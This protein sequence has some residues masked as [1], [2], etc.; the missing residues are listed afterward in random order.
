MFI[1]SS[2]AIS[3]AIFVKTYVFAINVM[4][5]FRANLKAVFLN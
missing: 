2:R 1:V 4:L 3:Q 5:A